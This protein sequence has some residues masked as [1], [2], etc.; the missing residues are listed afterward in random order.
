M[1]AAAVYMTVVATMA[2]NV[3][4]NRGQ[5]GEDETDSQ[6]DEIDREFHKHRPV[7]YRSQL[8]ANDA[9]GQDRKESNTRPTST[10]L[11][12]GLCTHRALHN[13]PPSNPHLQCRRTFVTPAPCGEI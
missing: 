2:E 7:D 8:N 12:I 10:W 9:V 5:Q 4:E 11:A 6:T 3:S 1:A 13:R